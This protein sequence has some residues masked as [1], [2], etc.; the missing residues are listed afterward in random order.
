MAFRL[1]TRLLSRHALLAFVGLLAGSSALAQ[2]LSVPADPVAAIEGDWNGI[3]EDWSV[4]VTNGRVVLTKSDPKTYSWLPVGTVL[5][6]LNNNGKSEPRAYRFSG[7]TCL[8]HNRDQSPSEYQIISCGD[9]GAVLSVYADSYELKVSGISLRRPK[10][11]SR[12]KASDRHVSADS[13]KPTVEK[14]QSKSVSEG[15]VPRPPKMT[16]AEADAKYDADM[17]E[18]KKQ[19]SDQ[20][21]Q[22]EAYKRAQ[23]D[24]ARKKDEQK[25][26]AEGAAADYQ[27]QLEAHAQT[28]RDQ[29]AEYQKE[30]AKPAGVPRAVYRGFTGADCDAARRSA[31]LGAGTSSTTRFKEVTS[32]ASGSGCLVQ[33]WWWNVPGGGTATRQ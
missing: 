23:E 6:V 11:A 17:A 3:W 29:Q 33:G 1:S 2:D 32:A 15:P 30:L 8:D 4:T 19:L 12:S 14:P 5:G 27:K 9:F 31:T 26:A 18:Y 24:V 22:V 20:Q 7:S 16:N 25:I 21:K 10:N 28:V 13:Q